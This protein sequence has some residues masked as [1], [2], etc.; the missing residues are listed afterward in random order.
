MNRLDTTSVATSNPHGFGDAHE[1]G[2]GLMAG[3]G[4]RDPE[5][6]SEPPG[7][8]S[9]LGDRVFEYGGSPDEL[10][11]LLSRTAVSDHTAGVSRDDSP[12]SVSEGTTDF[13]C[14]EVGH[15]VCI[16]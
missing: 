16:G 12:S 3:L 6:G 10:D 5:E 15:R 7:K 4:R 9:R 2:S 8:D 13:S 14:R 11:S 1:S